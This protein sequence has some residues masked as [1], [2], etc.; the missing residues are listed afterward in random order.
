M[1]PTAGFNDQLTPVFELP[2]T[3]AVNTCVA[4]GARLTLP[5]ETDKL[6]GGVRAT[7]AVVDFEGSAMLVAV[8]VT[9]CGT[10]TA[11]GAV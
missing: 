3:A 8:T 2:E 6:T 5:G 10:V 11:G 4:D 1:L 7:L 9:V